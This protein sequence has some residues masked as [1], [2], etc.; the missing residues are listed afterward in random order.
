MKDINKSLK[1]FADDLEGLDLVTYERLPD[2]E[3]Y[4]DQMLTYFDRVLNPFKLSTLDK[5]I[6]S[7]MIK[8][9]T[10]QTALQFIILMTIYLFGPNFIKEQDISRI[11]ENQII[12]KCFG[13]LPG[14]MT[15][16][17][18]IIY[19]IQTFWPNDV[20]IKKEMINNEFCKEY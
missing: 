9:V 1:L 12:L 16:P 7:S 15:D 20:Q 3:I 8:H 19:G 17:N 4:M 13:T 14:G 6:T 2:I 18:K 5:K 10:L 11:A